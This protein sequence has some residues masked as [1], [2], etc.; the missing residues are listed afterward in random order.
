MHTIEMNVIG[1]QCG[2]IAQTAK[3]NRTVVIKTELLGLVGVKNQGAPHSCIDQEFHFNPFDSDGNN[4]Q[5]GYGFE[6][7]FT[8]FI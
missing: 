6:R 1:F 4:H 3:K 5:I 7:N 8:F 2:L